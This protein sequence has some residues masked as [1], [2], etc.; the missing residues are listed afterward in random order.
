MIRIR[1]HETEEQFTIQVEGQLTGLFTEELERCWR[2]IDAGTNHKLVLNLNGVIHIDNVGRHLLQS[3]HKN[4]VVFA[5]ARLAT[6]DV[7]DEI[8]D[9][10]RTA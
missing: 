4:G 5:G 7:L 6:Q 2:A 9:I 10:D 1:V 3:M 8:M